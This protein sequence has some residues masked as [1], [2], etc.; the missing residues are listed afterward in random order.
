MKNTSTDFIISMIHIR[1]SYK[2]G[3]FH[4]SISLHCHF[5]YLCIFPCSHLALISVRHSH[6]RLSFRIKLHHHRP[7]TRPIFCCS[8][9]LVTLGG[10]PAKCHGDADRARLS[11]G[12]RVMYLWAFS[13]TIDLSVAQERKGGG[14]GESAG[15][16]QAG[17]D[18]LF[19]GSPSF[20]CPVMQG[21]RSLDP[22]HLFH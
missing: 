12:L 1:G 3:Y 5:H 10:R 2:R 14:G 11:R 6:A 22:L 21:D 4:S 17:A 8:I 13:R 9:P 20:G 19:R 18:A 15:G 16:R 7:P